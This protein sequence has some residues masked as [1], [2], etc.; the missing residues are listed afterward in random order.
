ML[1]SPTLSVVAFWHPMFDLRAILI[2]ALNRW[3]SIALAGHDADV[4]KVLTTCPHLIEV[5]VGVD[6]EPETLR[7][8]SAHKRLRVLSLQISTT[9][10]RLEALGKNGY[11]EELTGALEER[12]SS[13]QVPNLLEYALTGGL[14]PALRRIRM[15]DYGL[16]VPYFTSLIS[17]IGSRI[18][19]EV[20]I[21]R[22]HLCTRPEDIG[23]CIQALSSPQFSHSLRKIELHFSFGGFRSIYFDT[24]SFHDTF[25]PLLH[26]R[27]LRVLS[28]SVGKAFL[29][30]SDA[31]LDQMAHAWKYIITLQLGHGQ[32]DPFG[33]TSNISKPAKT[34]TVGTLVRIADQCTK[35]VHLQ[36]DVAAIKEQDARDLT[37]LCN[38]RRWSVQRREWLVEIETDRTCH[39]HGTE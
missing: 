19:A 5:L 7:Q 22:T 38:A 37:N 27:P 13:H 12:R 33:D 8:L 1:V 34:P 17:A 14:F 2:T 26:V 18:L 3:E 9:T 16:V 15:A 20:I 36:C 10:D 6:F 32:M 21:T 30:V 35:L 39:G 4:K 29:F 28:L 11:I 23:P 24:V 31:D 25:S